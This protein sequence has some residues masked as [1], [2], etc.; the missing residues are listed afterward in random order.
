VPASA[1]GRRFTYTETIADGIESAP[2]AFIGM[3]RGE[4]FGKQL[5]KLI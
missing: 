4:N 2:S 1:T 3:L 5:V